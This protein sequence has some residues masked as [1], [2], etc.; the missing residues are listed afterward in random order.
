MGKK[1][2]LYRRRR[3]LA[4]KQKPRRRSSRIA[5][6]HSRWT[7]GP[8]APARGSARP[9]AAAETSPALASPSFLPPLSF[10][11]TERPN[12]NE[13]DGRDDG[14]SGRRARSITQFWP[15]EET[16]PSPFVVGVPGRG[17]VA[18]PPSLARLVS[19]RQPRLEND[20]RLAVPVPV[21]IP[22]LQLW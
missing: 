20:G 17:A 19:Q 10:F 15:K 6:G 9:P 5:L 16:K 1:D 7:P 11:E 12:E 8:P 13:R 18:R 21:R 14:E 4:Q 2:H 3:P 22:T